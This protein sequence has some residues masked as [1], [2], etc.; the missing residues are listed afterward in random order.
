MMNLPWYRKNQEQ[1]K[2]RRRSVEQG[3]KDILS[4]VLVSQNG[5]HG[6]E[7]R[8]RDKGRLFQIFR[9]WIQTNTVPWTLV[10]RKL[11]NIYLLC[12]YCIMYL[13]LG[14]YW[15]SYCVT[16][17]RLTVC[18]VGNK[19]SC[20]Y[21]IMFHAFQTSFARYFTAQIRQQVEHSEFRITGA[22]VELGHSIFW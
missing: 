18:L 19:A 11:S 14:Y 8:H 7:E 9:I 16:P 22:R 6:E 12:F 4:S 3:L 13:V 20:N 5:Y 2:A 15:C 10:C 17:S 1:D 21:L